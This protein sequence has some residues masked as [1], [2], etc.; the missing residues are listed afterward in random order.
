MATYLFRMKQVPHIG[1]FDKFEELSNTYAYQS[2]LDINEITAKQVI[3][4]IDK[5]MTKGAANE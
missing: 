2:T 1:N 3:G 4:V 5:I